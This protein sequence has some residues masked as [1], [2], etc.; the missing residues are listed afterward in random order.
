MGQRQL[1]RRWF[2]IQPVGTPETLRSVLDAGRTSKRLDE[3]GAARV[4]H[5]IAEQVQAAQQKGGGKAVGPVTPSAIRFGAGGAA[6]LGLADRGHAIAYTAPEVL[7]GGAADK[8]SD[9]FSLG[10][11]LWEA[12]THQRLFDAMNDA[13][14]KVAVAE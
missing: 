9:V 10:V 1:A 6:E 3:L 14:V 7:A 13:A 8:R 4:V 5:K 12:L 2:T 11:V